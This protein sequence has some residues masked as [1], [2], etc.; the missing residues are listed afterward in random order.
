MGHVYHTTPLKGSAV[1]TEVGAERPQ[2]PEGEDFCNGAVLAR[3]HRAGA[4]VK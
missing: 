2:Q 3:R 4:H 1:N